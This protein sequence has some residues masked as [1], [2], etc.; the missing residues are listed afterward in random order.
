MVF[1]SLYIKQ[2]RMDGEWSSRTILE[3]EEEEAAE[4]VA[5]ALEALIWSAT[6]AVRL[7]ILL[8]SA[9]GVECLENV[10]VA[11]LLDIGGA[12]VMVAGQKKTSFPIYS[13]T[14][15]IRFSPPDFLFET[16]V[17]VL[18]DV[19]P[20]AEAHRLVVVA[21]ADLLTVDEMKF[22]MPMG[23]LTNLGIFY[24]VI[25]VYWTFFS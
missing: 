9:E 13:R 5:V 25:S 20:D 2:G 6:S 18:V 7:V 4:V 11:A 12:Q 16:G 1:S 23:E 3:E 21:I 22:L 17:I 24:C 19:R 14:W 8:V 10:E 15:Q